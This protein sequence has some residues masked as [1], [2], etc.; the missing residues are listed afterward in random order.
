[1]TADWFYFSFVAVYLAHM[2]EEYWT[3]FTRKFPPP[4]MSGT[5]ADKGFWVLNPFLLSVATAV[6]V[7]NLL[8]AAWAFFWAALWASICLW[9][10]AAH[11]IW[12]LLTHTYQPGLITGMFYAPLF[13]I[14]TWT[15]QAQ[16]TSD[17]AAF[18]SAVVIGLAIT[19]ALAGFAYLGRRV[20]R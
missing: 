10:A 8:G 1:M 14:W 17:W 18:W 16:G 12:S 9:N 3:G 2:Q 19:I 7:A 11:G 5:F 6:G 20:L 4:R 15:L 13:V